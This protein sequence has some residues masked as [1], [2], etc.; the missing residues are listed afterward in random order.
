MTHLGTTRDMDT[1]SLDDL[2]KAAGAAFRAADYETALAN[3]T[4]ALD[5]APGTRELLSNRA[6]C[7]A[8]ARE[9]RTSLVDANECIRVA[10]DW[11]KGWLRKGAALHGLGLFAEAIAAYQQ[12]IAA[13]PSVAGALRVGLADVQLAQVRAGGDWCTVLE[14]RRALPRVIAMGEVS[15]V[16]QWP[17]TAGVLGPAP[18]GFCLADPGMRHVRLYD[19]AGSLQRTFNAER[20][21]M[22]SPG[23][24]VPGATLN[25]PVGIACD[26]A[27]LYVADSYRR[28]DEADRGEAEAE[29]EAEA[30]D[31]DEA[32][33]ASR[34]LKLRVVDN[35]SL[36]DKAE[37]EKPSNEYSA[38]HHTLATRRAAGLALLDDGATRAVF[39]TDAARHRL[40]GLEA[41]LS[42][43]FVFGK[44]GAANG[45][46]RAP[47]GVAV[48]AGLLAVAD[49]GNRR[50]LV[51]GLTGSRL[52]RDPR[53]GPAPE[54]GALYVEVAP[55][56]GPARFA[57]PPRHVA[58]LGG[59]L[60]VAEDRGERVL[61][62]AL[63][64]GAPLGALVP[65]HRGELTGICRGG[66]GR[67]YVS[68][69][70]PSGHRI[71]ALPASAL[72]DDALAAN[73]AAWPGFQV[74]V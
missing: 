43:S 23:Q 48:A 31:E 34:V 30:E 33:G 61:V 56:D 74:S 11:G 9:Y 32:G 50:V 6:A 70:S 37:Q 42:L 35:R 24:L 67:L 26:A 20:P 18:E 16:P 41:D 64:S 19:S 66:D 38:P 4:R 45:E 15:P 8:A 51:L 53:A 14:P 52:A 49:T 1:T 58:L 47:G 2:K 5:I 39:V 44:R 65:P 36:H 68:S 57:A 7:N 72:T 73:R 60:L 3:Y 71:L 63:P 10:P 25:V 28:S 54:G 21:D 69:E 40:L 12:G 46:L 22:S 55:P 27:S 59:R 29:A 62:F 17:S 13:D